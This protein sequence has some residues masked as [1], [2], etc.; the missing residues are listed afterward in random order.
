MLTRIK[1]SFIK[2]YTEARAGKSDSKATRAGH[3]LGRMI[4]NLIR[5]YNHGRQR[6]PKK[7]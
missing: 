7:V 3:R 2:G 5:R 6:T 1:N 4:R